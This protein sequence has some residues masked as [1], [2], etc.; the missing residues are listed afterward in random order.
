M[1]K[2]D[3]D[4]FHNSLTRDL[5]SVAPIVKFPPRLRG[6]WMLQHY[7]GAVTYTSA[8]FVERNKDTVSTGGWGVWRGVEGCAC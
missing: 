6:Q 7:A 8:G 2:G 4:A 3:D 5:A 1:G